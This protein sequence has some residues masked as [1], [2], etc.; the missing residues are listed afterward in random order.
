MYERDYLLEIFFFIFLNMMF[1]LSN[2]GVSFWISHAFWNQYDVHIKKI[3]A[4]FPRALQSKIKRAS[5]HL[6]DKDTSTWYLLYESDFFLHT[7]NFSVP[8]MCY[9]IW[10]AWTIICVNESKKHSDVYQSVFTFVHNWDSSQPHVGSFCKSR[11]KRLYSWASFHG[12]PDPV[13]TVFEI[14]TEVLKLSEPHSFT[15]QWGS[16]INRVRVL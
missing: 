5:V 6:W 13:L 10:T 1:I 15:F 9:L 2:T 16:K 4:S 8:Y 12:H 11:G 7:L 14:L 3:N